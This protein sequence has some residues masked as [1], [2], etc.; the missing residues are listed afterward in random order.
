MTI[1]RNV[2]RARRRVWTGRRFTVVNGD[3][4]DVRQFV[5]PGSIDGL[6]ADPPY[7]LGISFSQRQV[8]TAAKYSQAATGPAVQSFEGDA[9]DERGLVAWSS[10]WCAAAL[11]VMVPGAPC[12]V[13]TDWRSFSAF[14]DG[15][16]AGG[17]HVRGQIG[18]DKGTSARPCPDRPRQQLENILW[19]S[20]G[21]WRP[22]HKPGI[23]PGVIAAPNV[24]HTKRLHI[25]EKPVEVI[26][27]LLRYVR[28]GGRVLDPFGG[29]GATGEAAL[30]AGFDVV[31][32]ERDPAIAAIAAA[33]LAAVERVRA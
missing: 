7:C 22:T 15:L 6:I 26:T 19:G 24:N 9:R 32:I 12:F 30:R 5:D 11:E 17:W 31:I 10:L 23:G 4:L 29:S 20:A 18:W 13:F 25:A 2:R 8:G 3:A 33:R 28:P 1:R 16:S 14:R 21:P 27:P